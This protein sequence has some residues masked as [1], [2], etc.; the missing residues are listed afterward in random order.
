MDEAEWLASNYPW[1]MLDFLRGKTS[2]RKLRLFGVNCCRPLL[3]L[4]FD[5]RSRAVLDIAE[6]YA[7]GGATKSE[8]TAAR[9]RAEQAAKGIEPRWTPARSA[10]WAACWVASATGGVARGVVAAITASA[11]LAADEA[12]QAAQ[13]LGAHDSYVAARVAQRAAEREAGNRAADV[14]RD[15]VGNPYK[16]VTLDPDW[17][18]STVVLLARG[19]YD[20][21]AFDR[22]PILA[23]ALQDAGC[24]AEEV[25]NHCRGPGPHVRG[26]HVLDLIL[27]KE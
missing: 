4:L 12:R 5:D 27:G 17:L 6:R 16:P 11:Q 8:L 13:D 24:D 25:L 10:A 2:A 23:D 1:P 15:I 18:T 26:C 19:I 7:D 9:A 20:E 22:M 21:R 14:L 3:G